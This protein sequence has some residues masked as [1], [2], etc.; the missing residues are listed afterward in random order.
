MMTSQVYNVP[1]RKIEK[2]LA[3]PSR[4]FTVQDL[5]V[6]WG[7]ADDVALYSNIHYYLRAGRL[8]KVHRGMYALG[9]YTSFELGQKLVVPSY[10]SFYT[11]LGVHG[12]IFQLYE[13]KH[14]MALV[15]K[16]IAVGNETF[17]YHKLRKDIFFDQTGA[18]YRDNCWIASPERAICDSLYLVPGLAFDNLRMVNREKLLEIAGLYKNKRL[19]IEVRRL[20]VGSN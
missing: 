1:L 20:D 13:E 16:K 11:A 3:S 6:L 9:E 4:V 5:G 7:V 17:V 15:S 2:L 8:L 10:V 14:F 12:V 18:E 19:M